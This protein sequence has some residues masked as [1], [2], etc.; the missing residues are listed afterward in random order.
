MIRYLSAEDGKKFKEKTVLLRL[1]FNTTD[2]WRM[3]ASLPTLMFLAQHARA[4]VVL[5]H[6][7]RPDGVDKKLSLKKDAALLAKLSRK[8]TSFIP[9]FD[10]E[11]I[12]VQI[13]K[14]KK[15]SVFVLENLRFLPGE[16]KN[17]PVLAKKL[18]KLGDVYVNDAFAVSHR[19]NA[20]VVALAKLLPSYA[21]FGLESEIA[22]LSKVMKSPKK[23][24]VMILGGAKISDKLD[25]MR[26][27]QDS[28]DAFLMG[29]A[30]AN[31]LLALRG[32]D[33]GRSLVEKDLSAATK[34]VLGYSHL[35]LPVDFAKKDRALLDIG[36]R[37][38]DIFARCIAMAHTVVWNG[39]M[40]MA[41][42]K[43]FEKGTRAVAEA[44]AANKNCFSVVGGGE[45]VTA[46]KKLKM[47]K[48]M[49]FISTG[50]GAMLEYLSGKKLPGIE[51]LRR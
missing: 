51:A 1:D 42:K 26:N 5:S 33:V 22:N 7:G 30:L 12:G 36:P 2:D 3:R 32:F 8:K 25:L 20:S 29:G 16:A 48:K 35:F 13:G 24:L 9:H 18:A 14:A 41:E 15:G 44:I 43:G 39:P 37:T 49:S 46:L 34:K 28:T 4:V 47:D 23:P 38:A 6:K 27:F 19:K 17:D 10:F 21:G 40:G 11:K 50:G 31:T 45:T